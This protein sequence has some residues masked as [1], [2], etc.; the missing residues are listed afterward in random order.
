M[1]KLI[2][3]DIDGTLVT[4]DYR[5]L[6]STYQALKKCHEKGIEIVLASGRSFIEMG[7]FFEKMP[8]IDYVICGNGSSVFKVKTQEKLHDQAIDY[9]LI[10]DLAHKVNHLDYMI[11][12]Y[13]EGLVYS[14]NQDYDTLLKF[15]LEK[16]YDYL[17]GTRNEVDDVIDLLVQNNRKVEKANFNFKNKDD[18]K[19]AFEIANNFDFNATSSFHHNIEVSHKDAHKGNGVLFLS[20]YLNI[21]LD[22]MMAFGDGLNDVEMVDFVK[23][24]IAMGNAV[25]A[26]KEKAYEI[27]L[28]NDEGG[29]AHMID[30]YIK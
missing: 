5:F 28:T 25:E 4:S 2:A 14:Q 8:F 18:Q 7:E 1:I 26:L 3:L 22:E 16:F 15:G 13:D 19:L 23:Y 20:K 27:T 9:K 30:K 24:G 12:F 11:E 29:I 21:D 10:V 6:D 17:K